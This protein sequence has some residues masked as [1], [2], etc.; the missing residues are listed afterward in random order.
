MLP[1]EEHCAQRL[2]EEQEEAERKRSAEHDEALEAAEI[3]EALGLGMGAGAYQPDMD[4][5][6]LPSQPEPPVKKRKVSSK[7]P[8]VSEPSPMA[9]ECSGELG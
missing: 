9:V 5:D 8:K 4:D 3:L 6:V 7:K 2:N 1:Y